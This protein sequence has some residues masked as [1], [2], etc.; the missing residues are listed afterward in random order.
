MA[1][2]KPNADDVTV[3]A[4]RFFLPFTFA[5]PLQWH[6]G[7]V[8]AE[9]SVAGCRAV[10]VPIVAGAVTGK[11]PRPG[12]ARRPGPVAVAGGPPVT[13]VQRGHAVFA[14]A[15]AEL[16]VTEVRFAHACPSDADDAAAALGE[17][18]G[19]GGA[20][21]SRRRRQHFVTIVVCTPPS[22]P[23]AASPDMLHTG[24]TPA[25]SEEDAAPASSANKGATKRP[26]SAPGGR[27]PV[28]ATA[29]TAARIDSGAAMHHLSTTVARVALPMGNATYT[30]CVDSSRRE[31]VV[32]DAAG[33]VVGR[34]G[35]WSVS[36]VAAP[37]ATLRLGVSVT[38]PFTT[39]EFI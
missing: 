25:S 2:R 21:D 28:A 32:R 27:A 3:A 17:D 7:G 8:N 1:G 16:G 4:A 29:A 38:R 35:R 22:T 33:D 14:A 19:D 30:A 26:A 11:P 12:S 20:A 36:G 23:P 13:P 15:I 9:L 18:G 24:E 34:D 6:G 10:H 39:V 5:G 31:L 37:V